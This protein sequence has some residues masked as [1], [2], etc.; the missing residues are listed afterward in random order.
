LAPSLDTDQRTLPVEQPHQD[1][2]QSQARAPLPAQ[3][4]DVEIRRRAEQ[5]RLSVQ[6]KHE[7]HRCAHIVSA[8]SCNEDVP[9]QHPQLDETETHRRAERSHKSKQRHGGPGPP[10]AVP[11][12]NWEHTQQVKVSE[13]DAPRLAEQGCQEKERATIVQAA[14]E[15]DR[16]KTAE[17]AR[18]IVEKARCAEEIEARLVAEEAARIESE[19]EARRCTEQKRRD[20]QRAEIIRAAEEYDR[21]KAAEAHQAAE[22]ARRI[23]EG[24]ARRIAEETRRAAEQQAILI[25]KE[26]ARRK[27]EEDNRLRAE[28]EARLKA[29]EDTSRRAERNR[30]RKERA[31]IVKAAKDYDRRKAAEHARLVAEEA[32]RIAADQA[33]VRAQ[34]AARLKAEEEDARR[35]AEEA[36]RLRAAEE[37]LE[38]ARRV[39]EQAQ[40]AQFQTRSAKE[41][42]FTL[43]HVA[44]GSIITFAA[45]LEIRD[46]VPAFECR[47]V[48]I[49]NLPADA[50]VDE[51]RGLFGQLCI[52]AERFHLL[53]L[54]PARSGRQQAT[55]VIPVEILTVVSSAING[56][57]FRNNKMEFEVC[58]NHLSGGMNISASP[59]ASLLSVSWRGPSVRFVAEYDELSQAQAKV[60][61]LNKTIHGEHRLSVDMNVLPP[62]RIVTGYNPASIRIQG[63]PRTI[64]EDTV[65]ALAE[66]TRIRRLPYKNGI[67]A[68]VS[69]DHAFTQILHE[70]E[71]LS[72]GNIVCHE[73][74]AQERDREL[75][76]IVS[77][78]IRFSSTEAA[79]LVHDRLQGRVFPGVSP[80]ALWLTPPQ[81]FSFTIS[82]S[83]EQY[84]AQKK[85]WDRLSRALSERKECTLSAKRMKDVVYV[86][87]FGRERPAIGIAKVR[88]E[89][90]ASG[91]LV[92]GWNRSLCSPNN[93]FFRQ[94]SRDTGAHIRVDWRKHAIY[95]YGESGPIESA[96]AMVQAELKRLE[97]Q[98]HTVVLKATSVGFFVR[99]GLAALKG[100]VGA[101][102]VDFHS[103]ARR[104]T[105]TGGEKA[106]HHLERL[107][108]E[109]ENSDRMHPP[110]TTDHDCAICF[111]AVASP[112]RIGCGHVY[113]EGCLVDWFTNAVEN[114][115]LPI[116]CVADEARCGRPVAIP[117]I[118]KYLPQAKMRELLEGAAKW[119]I[120]TAA[121][122]QY[123]KT[124]DCTQIYRMSDQA[125]VSVL[126]C[127][128]CFAEV[129]T[130]CGQDG[131][132]DVSC[133]EQRRIMLQWSL[134]EGWM[135]TQGLKKCPSCGR[136]L[137]PD[138]SRLG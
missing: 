121:D 48:Q 17:Q 115:Q 11:R 10:E 1:K 53:P 34:E 109:S 73:R 21:R 15:Y 3:P 13:S 124:T 50:Q 36:K 35:R 70:V 105:V 114:E 84:E 39:R 129:C 44:L 113:C 126:Q 116:R 83:R 22:V 103:S 42:A 46:L 68:Q 63:L 104:I 38:Q 100:V 24:E 127:P 93:G 136:W 78:G 130:G 122:F 125:S 76:G 102:A 137:P 132:Q 18:Q 82:I 45:G 8:A 65:R 71:Q 110:S 47:M 57:H 41:A 52:E 120:R 19:A 27:E 23:A 6:R 26:D 74:L 43:K 119:H 99:R 28:E 69:P 92:N 95:L 133:E 117:T 90:L 98:E 40:E 97:T 112:S 4:G 91:D 9:V 138:P 88:V 81:P 66:T 111:C 51:I 80:Q 61:A 86:R 32:R 58:G 54:K 12:S 77:F 85:L 5:S 62:G 29:E 108:K 94:V 135:G 25:A 72:P 49:K 128:A 96:R 123:C 134:D 56:V 67:E 30:Q 31:A 59:N 37:E 2:K 131:H 60:K 89:T 107:L 64:T 106:R 33:R 101:D 7:Q 14:E 16:L 75:E 79:C 55:V 87:L 20:Q 118:Q